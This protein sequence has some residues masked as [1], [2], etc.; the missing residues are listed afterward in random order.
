MTYFQLD[1]I[2]TNLVSNEREKKQSFPKMYTCIGLSIEI[3]CTEVKNAPWYKTPRQPPT[4]M[5]IQGLINLWTADSV[6]THLRQKYI[7]GCLIQSSTLH[8]VS[9][10]LKEQYHYHQMNTVTENYSSNG[11]M[12]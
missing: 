2:Q 7:K 11:N 1:H 4:N 6:I 8:Q 10:M 12:T 9:L 3:R 5:T